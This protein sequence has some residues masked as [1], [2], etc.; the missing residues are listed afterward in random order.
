M[1]HRAAH[2]GFARGWYSVAQSDAVGADTL[3]PVYCLDQQLVVYRTAAGIVQAADAY[4]PHLGAHLA[5]HDGAIVDGQITCPFHKWRWDGDTGRCSHIP[6]ASTLPPG[7]VKL[8]LHPTREVDGDVVVWHDPTGA[9]PDFEP[10]ASEAFRDD[11]WTLFDRRTVDTTCPFPDIFENLFDAAH[12]VQ[13]HRA[14]RMPSLLNTASRPHGLYVEYGI[15]PDAED[16]ALEK[17]ALN[18]T[19]ITLLN[20]H[21][22]GRGWEA[23]FFIALTPLDFETTRQSYRLYLKDMGSAQAHEAL[24]KPFVERFVY[25]VE[26]D[27]K[28]INFKKHL[29]TPKLCRG[30]GPIYQ[31]RE[32]ASKYL[33]S[34]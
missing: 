4:C 14:K 23:L 27:M 21:Y 28:V 13:L 25:E 15:D 34:G 24:G 1:R 11:H 2:T 20:Q 31:Y 12:I 26:Q 32:Y 29:P 8:T 33:R 10:Y 5:S 3:L 7:T 16:Q 19:G 30:D 18:F 17:I 22:V 6:Y 9:E